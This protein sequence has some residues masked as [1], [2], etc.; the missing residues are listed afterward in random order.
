MTLRLLGRLFVVPLLL[1]TVPAIAFAQEAV[2]SGT[3]TDLTGAVLP[4]VTITAVHQATG[5]T[6][7][8][9]TDERGVYRIAARAGVYRLTAELLGFRAVTRRA[10]S[11]SSGKS[12]TVNLPMLEAT[13]AETVTVTA[14]TPLAGV[15]TSSLGGNV[16][17][18]Q[19]QELPVNG[20]NWMDLALLAPGSRTV[21]DQRDDAAA[22]PEQRRGAGVPAQHRRPAGVVGASGPAASR[23][24]A[25]IRSRSSS[26]SRT[27]STRRRADRPA[28]RSTRSPSPAATG[29]RALPR[30]L[31][32]QQI[33]RR[34]TRSSAASCRS[35]TSSSARR[36]AG[37]I[38]QG[39]AALLRQLRIRARAADQH[40][41][42]AVPG[43]Q[44]RSRRR[45]TRR[46]WA[47]CASTISSRRRRA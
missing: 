19:V 43:V 38:V 22:G 4:G 10:C 23:G 20:R 8:A 30:Q 28:C 13:A 9:V 39:Q 3:V 42:H 26:S 47:A 32:Q 31:P 45:R 35:T 24:T 44:R 15:A 14:E 2:L 25:R 5:N 16:D 41:E 34:R 21:V 46:N 33:Q 11:C 7:T 18:R 37:R 36:S 6:F 27:G 12:M 1:A 29:S 17:P 40:L